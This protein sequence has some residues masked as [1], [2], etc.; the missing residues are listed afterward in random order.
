M[1]ENNIRRLAK[2][3][4]KTAADIGKLTMYETLFNPSIK[5]LPPN[6]SWLNEFKGEEQQELLFYY[7][8]INVI[9]EIKQRV[10]TD[11]VRA[12]LALTQLLLAMLGASQ[13]EELNH[14]IPDAYYKSYDVLEGGYNELNSLL[15]YSIAGMDYM[16]QVENM[17]IYYKML[18]KSYIN[19]MNFNYFMELM[20]KKFKME[21]ML[22]FQMDIKKLFEKVDNINEI[23]MELVMLVNNN[24][25]EEDIKLL[26]FN[27]LN[28][29]LPPIELSWHGEN[30][31]I[32][33]SRKVLNKRYRDSKYSEDI[34][35][36][37]I[38]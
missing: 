28:E 19:I 12:D 3:E 10:T 22:S 25:D 20:A 11:I 34:V 27:V 21:R 38:L 8:T 33:L 30:D 23:R 18:E 17:K 13:A 35:S 16:E 2:K 26:K 29:V 14:V 9:L 31:M 24:K 32:K 4:R 37:V 15:S 6:K 36:H 1:I 7:Q 5:L